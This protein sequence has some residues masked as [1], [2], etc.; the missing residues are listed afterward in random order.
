MHPQL[1]ERVVLVEPPP[2]GIWFAVEPPR[3]GSPDDGGETPRV[4]GWQRLPLVTAPDRDIAVSAAKQTV[5]EFAAGWVAAI[6]PTIRP[7]TLHS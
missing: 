1:D 4:V 3:F 6:E 2:C 5:A 7:S